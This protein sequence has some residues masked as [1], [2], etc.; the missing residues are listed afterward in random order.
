MAMVGGDQQIIPTL[1]LAGSTSS[2][3]KQQDLRTGS[4]QQQD[5]GNGQQ[6]VVVVVVVRHS[7]LTFTDWFLIFLPVVKGI[8][9]SSLASPAGEI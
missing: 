9:V 4:S 6:Q 7:N 5:D 8:G 2:P 1:M 3:W